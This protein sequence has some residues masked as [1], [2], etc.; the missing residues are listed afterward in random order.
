MKELAQ[1]DHLRSLVLAGSQITDRG[2]RHLRLAHHL[3][4][5]DLSRTETTS[6]ARTELQQDLPNCQVVYLSVIERL[7]RS[8][9]TGIAGLPGRS[10]PVVK[11]EPRG[12]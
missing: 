7:P 11:T 4:Y 10:L 12:R 8:G 1:R 5:L 9:Q 3:E 6:E 2:I